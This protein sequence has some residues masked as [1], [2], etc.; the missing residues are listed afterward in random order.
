SVH[1]GHTKGQADGFSGY[2]GTHKCFVVL[3]PIGLSNRLYVLV[4]WQGHRHIYAVAMLLDGR[5][6]RTLKDAV[7]PAGRRVVIGISLSS[8]THPHQLLLCTK[9]D[10]IIFNYII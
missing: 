1:S 6:I 8:H 2:A 7:Q 10:I 5:E 3:L 4:D 9:Q